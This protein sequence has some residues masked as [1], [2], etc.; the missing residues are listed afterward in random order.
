[1]GENAIKEINIEN[2]NYILTIYWMIEGM[3]LV[4][5]S[6]LVEENVAEVFLYY[7]GHLS[8]S[9]FR[10]IQENNNVVGFPFSFHIFI[11]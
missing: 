9:F 3:M 6:R 10:S 1:M 4:I 8:S 2:T 5:R 7:D 11:P